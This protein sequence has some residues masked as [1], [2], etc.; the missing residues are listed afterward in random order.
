MATVLTK[1][2]ALK[3]WKNASWTELAKAAHEKRIQI[4]GKKNVSY[5]VFRIINYTNIC[6]IGCSFCS[7]KSTAGDLPY[8]LSFGEIRTL[9]LKARKQG[10]S[11][12]FLQGGV[13]SNITLD[14]Y[15]KVLE[16]LN[17][18]LKFPVRGFSPVELFHLAKNSKMPLP[19][20][21][22]RLKAAGLSSVPGAGAEIMTAKMRKIL[23]PK[24]LSAKEWCGVM[25]ECHRQGLKG[26]ANIVVGSTESP[27]DI[28][29]HLNYIREVQNKTG[30]FQSF[31]PWV[32]QP[33]TDDF[34]IRHVRSDEYI[35]LV[36]LCRLFFHNIPNIEVSVLGMGKVLGELA[37]YA[38]A[39]D[40]SSVVLE[41]RVMRSQGIAS[42][43]EA[44]EFIMNAGFTAV[45]RGINY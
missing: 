8:T 1:K 45:R 28:V 33:Q 19:E 26:S 5:T 43:E 13:N 42:I 35:K 23:S 21:L 10:A 27:E 15:L 14:Y 2:E 4:H 36:A 24:K 18:K 34:P 16:L 25:E 12:I 7:F 3:L 9:A 11:G 39:N 44:E 20:L 22:Q 29:E 30:G 31:I 41:E 17:K 6:K 32:F 37:L 40:I 38:G